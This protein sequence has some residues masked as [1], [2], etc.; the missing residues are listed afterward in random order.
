MIELVKTKPIGAIVLDAVNEEWDQ[1]CRIVGILWE[2]STTAGDR[3]VINGR[4][5]NQMGTIWVARTD[6]S[7]T[8][9]G[10]IWGPPGIHAPDGFRVEHLDA[11]TLYVYLAE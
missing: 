9:L 7:N 1:S 5:E 2:G 10:A 8:Y 3:A 4:E 6:T 11:G